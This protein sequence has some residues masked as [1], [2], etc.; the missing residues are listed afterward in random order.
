MNVTEV[1]Q[2]SY[3]MCYLLG[4]SAYGMALVIKN[5]ASELG[6]HPL[7]RQTV[8][9]PAVPAKWRAGDLRRIRP[10][11]RGC[12]RRPAERASIVNKES[13]TR[14]FEFASC[15]PRPEVHPSPRA[16]RR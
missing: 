12:C 14:Y 7:F 2:H 11:R 16:C 10:P 5:Q 15:L 1:S 13:L 6:K 4:N 8:C 9:G 3:C